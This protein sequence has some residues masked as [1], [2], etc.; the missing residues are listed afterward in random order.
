[1]RGGIWP[2]NGCR[3]KGNYRLGDWLWL[4]CH[5]GAG[6]GAGLGG[7]EQGGWRLLFT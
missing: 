2:V 3:R 5:L 1:M 7:E 4:L 6:A